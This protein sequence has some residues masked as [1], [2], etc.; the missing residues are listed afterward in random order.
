MRYLLLIILMIPTLLYGATG[1]IASVAGKAVTAI[2]TINGVAGTAIDNI[3]G[4]NYADGDGGTTCSTST[5]SLQI[6]YLGTGSTGGVSNYA[7]VKHVL[8]SNITIT[9]YVARYRYDSGDGTVTIC[10]L[11]HNT[12]TDLPNGTTCISGT[13]S[14][15]NDE[16]MGGTS[17]SNKTHTLTTPVN[18]DAGTYWICNIEGGS[19]ARSFEFYSSSG[20]RSCYGT[21]S[22]G[23]ADPDYV[24]GSID[25]YGCTR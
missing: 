17:Y 7:C 15:K 5:D 3:C 14:S 9:E 16:D 25:V 1:D 19:I 6:H 22:C 10:L 12:S 11:P 23:V 24:N 20:K 21:S 2:S 4:K 18:V 8:T 13:A